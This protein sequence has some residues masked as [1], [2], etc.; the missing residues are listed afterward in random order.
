MVNVWSTKDEPIAS[1]RT[2]MENLRDK[3]PED[4][5][6]SL[7]EKWTKAGGLSLDHEALEL[8]GLYQ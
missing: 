6:T 3:L 1:S 7:I 8:A 2:A 5:Y 4:E